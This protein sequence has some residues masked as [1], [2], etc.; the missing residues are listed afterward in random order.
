MK[1]N[2]CSDQPIE[3]SV[4]LTCIERVVTHLRRSWCGF[5]IF[6]GGP[7]TFLYIVFGFQISVPYK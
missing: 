1:V 6:K 3:P 4:K 2:A 5:C 7:M